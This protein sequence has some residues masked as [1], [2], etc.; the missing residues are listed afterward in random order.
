VP[1]RQPVNHGGVTRARR[2]GTAVVL[3]LLACAAPGARAAA[4][5]PP[6]AEPAAPAGPAPI[7]DDLGRARPLEPAPGFTVTQT[8]EPEV[9]YPSRVFVV[10]HGRWITVPDAIFDLFFDAHPGLSNASAGLAVELGPPEDQVWAIA[11]DWS[12]YAPTAGNWLAAT[13]DPAAATY[14]DG[15]LHLLSIDVNY[16]RQ[17]A[18]TDSFRAFLGA[19]L[20]VGVLL[21]DIHLAEVLPTCEEP[22]S[23]CAHWPNA[24]DRNAELP[25]RVVPIIHLTAGME[26]DFGG[27]LLRLQG[28]FRNALYLGLSI[29]AEL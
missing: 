11:F 16:R 10:A 29:G 14:A 5:T 17:T 19:G 6:P 18:F 20:G 12:A 26:V 23:K 27:F 15:A 1:T 24:S 13:E 28:G 7:L 3:L 9:E 2:L 4:P 8:K 25:T 22:V 21:G